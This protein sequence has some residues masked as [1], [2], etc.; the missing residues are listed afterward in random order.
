MK[1]SI[2]SLALFLVL[3]PQVSA[4]QKQE[5]PS[6]HIQNNPVLSAG[7]EVSSEDR[8]DLIQSW[9]AKTEDFAKAKDWGMSLALIDVE[10]PLKYI[11]EKHP[12]IFSCQ[13]SPQDVVALT[14][15]LSVSR[16][17]LTAT[18]K[19][20]ILEVLSTDFD[21]PFATSVSQDQT[22]KESP[23]FPKGLLGSLAEKRGENEVFQVQSGDAAQIKYGLHG[24][25]EDGVKSVVVPPS[26]DMGPFAQFLLLGPKLWD[27]SFANPEK[28]RVIRWDVSQ[29]SPA[30]VEDVNTGE[31]ICIYAK[32]G[33]VTSAQ[34]IPDLR[35]H[36]PSMQSEKD[37][38]I[39]DP[40]SIH[41]RKVVFF[42]SD[43]GLKK[44]SWNKE[45][46]IEDLLI[47]R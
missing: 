1:K 47:R 17:S 23:F 31:K 19:N 2:L 26:E 30:L 32:N 35:P 6:V 29:K 42:V 3:L 38:N 44:M 10:L 25:T 16:I 21:I 4:A 40:K 28:F 15:P 22:Q 5:K 45:D 27:V 18:Y 14:L 11:E 7:S 8:K 34:F 46:I 41:V 13:T 9:K 39:K 43:P 33:Q 36:Q 12:N 24:K 20:N 37:E